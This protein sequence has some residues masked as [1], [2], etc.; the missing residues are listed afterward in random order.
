[1]GVVYTRL[2]TVRCPHPRGITNPSEPVR[3]CNKS[4]MR[5]CSGLKEMSSGRKQC[6]YKTGFVPQEYPIAVSRKLP[7]DPSSL[8]TDP[9]L[10]WTRRGECTVSWAHGYSSGRTVPTHA[11]PLTAGGD[12]LNM[13]RR[14]GMHMLRK[15]RLYLFLPDYLA[16]H[17]T[18]TIMRVP[19][20]RRERGGA[21]S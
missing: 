19:R 11:A 20:R 2:T 9:S 14:S 4:V 10:V 12:C 8:Y 18:K 1:M 17:P 15:V 6:Y 21:R 5:Q 13:A 16:N 7:R 3:R